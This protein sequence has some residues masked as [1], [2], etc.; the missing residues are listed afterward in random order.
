MSSVL[1]CI[2]CVDW[3]LL[4]V[5]RALDLTPTNVIASMLKGCATVDEIVN[6]VV[7]PVLDHMLGGT[8]CVS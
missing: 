2:V 7:I 1:I 6:L 4:V 5:Y 3:A 8:W